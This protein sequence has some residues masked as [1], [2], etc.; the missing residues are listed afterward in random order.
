MKKIFFLI[1][2]FISALGYGQK[3]IVMPTGLKDSAN[4]EKTYVI[5]S[6]DGLTAKQLYDNAIKYVNKT[7]K[8]PDEVIKGKIE[9]EYLKINTYASKFLFTKNGGVKVFFVAKYATEMSFKDGK[10][11][12]EIIDLEMYNPDNMI[13]LTFVGG[14]LS[15]CVF[16]KKGDLKREGIKADIETYFN[17]EIKR[18]IE[19]LKGGNSSTENW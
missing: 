19:A 1:A 4:S 3:L 14:G 15:W 5:L 7:Y 6:V 8:N 9:S 17:A 10:V 18:V 11:K 13:P 2:L 12:Y 16:N